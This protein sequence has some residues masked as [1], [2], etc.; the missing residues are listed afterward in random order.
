MNYNKGCYR[1]PGG[2]VCRHPLR[3]NPEI[4]RRPIQRASFDDVAPMG[5]N[6]TSYDISATAEMNNE[7]AMVYSPYQEWQNI[8]SGEKALET[9]TLFAEL[10]KP[11]YGYKC[12]KGGCLL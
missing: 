10:D 9:G 4:S 8:Y 1:Q 2:N 5:C 7:L 6:G 11:F 3:Q 12:T